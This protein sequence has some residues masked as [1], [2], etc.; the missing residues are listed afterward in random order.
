[1]KLSIAEKFKFL[2]ENAKR[3]EL[4]IAKWLRISPANYAKL[5]SGE[6]D[7]A[8]G[9]IAK[10]A[11]L[12]DLTV[13]ELLRVGEDQ[14]EASYVARR[15]YAEISFPDGKLMKIYDDKLSRELAE[16][17]VEFPE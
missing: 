15:L 6:K 11:R 1:M 5:E 13:L 8:F 17:F 16:L 14:L 4:E 3:N 12:Y 10:V 2:R 9:F 7:P